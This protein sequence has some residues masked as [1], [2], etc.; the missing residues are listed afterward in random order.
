MNVG[1]LPNKGASQSALRLSR[2]GGPHVSRC[3]MVL[4][5]NAREDEIF[6]YR[7]TNGSY[8]SFGLQRLLCRDAGKEAVDELTIFLE[9]PVPPVAVGAASAASAASAAEAAEAADGDIIQPPSVRILGVIY[10]P[11]HVSYVIETIKRS[12]ERCTSVRRYREFD[13]FH[14]ITGAWV[15]AELPPKRYLFNMAF[16]FVHLRRRLLQEYVD[17]VI[18]SRRFQARLLHFLTTDNPTALF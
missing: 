16:D 12:G 5:D 10:K 3:T 2:I 14:E 15:V 1:E 8:L 7:H 6:V 9:P 17:T 4:T 18:K 13:H 11:D